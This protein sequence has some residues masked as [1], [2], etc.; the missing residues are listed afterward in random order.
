MPDA[1][2][3]WFDAHKGYGF[4]K[5]H[6]GSTDVFVH[7]TALNASRLET[8]LEGQEVSYEL[9]LSEKSG[10]MQAQ[11]IKILSSGKTPP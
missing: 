10:K 2:V 6:D 3:K 4:L 9:A 11:N 8:L 7:H 5:P 1:T